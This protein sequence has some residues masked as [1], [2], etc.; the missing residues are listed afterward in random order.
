VRGESEKFIEVKTTG[1]GK[2]FPFYVT[3]IEVRCADECPEPFRLY[4]VFDYARS[5]RVYVVDG[6]LSR[7][8]QL[9]PVAYL[10]S[11]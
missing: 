11:F 2:Q 4:L 8:C 5:P 1:L 7:M 9:D 6:S 3:A 10:A